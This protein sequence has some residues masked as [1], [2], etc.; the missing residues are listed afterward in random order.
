MNLSMPDAMVICTALGTII[1]AIIRFVPARNEQPF[2]HVCSEHSGVEA[3][4]KALNETLSRLQ[5]TMDRL[6]E[7]LITVLHERQGNEPGRTAGPARAD[8]AA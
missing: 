1:A 4:I 8:R 7:L 5:D 6:Q 3:S 2:T